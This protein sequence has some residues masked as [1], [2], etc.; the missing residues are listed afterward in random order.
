MERSLIISKA[1][2]GAKG[3]RLAPPKQMSR[4]AV[5][6]SLGNES[7]SSLDFHDYRPYQLGDDL[8]RVDWGVYARTDSLVIRQY[9]VEVSPVVEVILDTSKSMGLYDGKI[10]GAIYAAAFIATLARNA[11]GRPVLIQSDKRNVD[12][13]FEPS[14]LTLDFEQTDNPGDR[15]IAET[16]ARSIRILISDLLF[17]SDMQN[18]FSK[19][20]RNS[21]ELVVIHIMSKTEREPTFSGGVRMSD[22]ESPTR[23]IDM[24]VDNAARHRYKKNLKRHIDAITDAATRYHV[25]MINLTVEDNAPESY[26]DLQQNLSHALLRAGVMEAL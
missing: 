4:G 25:G 8:R 23:P 16:T 7:G 2:S 11:E 24:R 10:A 3:C 22:I 5:G 14:L 19:L 18:L 9:Q 20:S 17:P 1:T 15:P 21:T 12:S 26:D 6:M 13:T